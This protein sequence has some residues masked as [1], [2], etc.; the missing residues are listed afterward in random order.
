MNDQ[1]S[2]NW[3]FKRLNVSVLK[4]LK[5]GPEKKKVESLFYQYWTAFWN[6]KWTVSEVEKCK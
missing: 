2:Q 3:R 6:S 1:K 5:Y 4:E